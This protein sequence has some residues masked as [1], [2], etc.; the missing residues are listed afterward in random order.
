MIE[1]IDIYPRVSFLYRLWG[2]V[3]L[4]PLPCGAITKISVTAEELVAP[5]WQL[6]GMMIDLDHSGFTRLTMGADKLRVGTRHWAT[7]KITCE[8]FVAQNA[9]VHCAQ[10]FLQT[11]ALI[12]FV[13]S[14]RLPQKSLDITLVPNSQENWQAKINWGQP[15]Q[16]QA[17]IRNGDI[18]R[19]SPWLPK[20]IPE[21]SSGQL[22]GTLQAIASGKNVSQAEINLSLAQLK[23]SDAKGLH[24]GEK[25]SAA[26]SA[27]IQRRNA[28]WDW[29]SLAAWKAGE[30]FW[31]PWYAKAAHRVEARGS[32]DNSVIRVEQGNMSWT[33]IGKAEF[34]G[35]WQRPTAKWQ[36][37]SVAARDIDLGALQSNFLAPSLRQ[38][39][40]AKL[41]TRGRVDI[42][43]SYL[44]GQVES[45]ELT[46]RDAMLEDGERRFRLAGINLRLP[47]SKQTAKQGDL[48]IDNLN[49]AK[50]NMGPIV[51]QIQTRG[52][53]L[54][55][56]TLI[57]PLLD[58]KLKLSDLEVAKTE[59]GWQAAV[60]G[61]LTP[62]NMQELAPM[63][64]LPAMQGELSGKF[65]R[66]TFREDN[67]SAEGNLTARMFD[68]TVT[69]ENFSI[70]KLFSSA[71]I[72]NLDVAMRNLDLALLTRAFSFGTME[73][74]IDV[75]IQDLQTVNWQPLKFDA[76]LQSSPGRYPKK[77]SQRAVQ[78]ISSLGGAGPAAAL[79]RSFLSFF[80]QFGYNRLALSC[81]LKD[82]VCTMG[83]IEPKGSGFV[84]VEGGGIPAI[85]VLG[86]NR[87]VGWAELVARLGRITK[88]STA[89][90]K[91][92][93]KEQ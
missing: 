67:L 71:P 76:R 20:A 56:K 32:A 6:Q 10:G 30:I 22:N 66:L 69:V 35:V 49:V 38:P 36:T 1:E 18:K 51:T 13:F 91:P 78:N 11:D 73:G 80:E 65:P 62:V 24:A 59:K 39:I 85:T 9:V 70:A 12:P 81:Q 61:E 4:L 68:G 54:S 26:I 16:V 83:G 79:Q 3:L 47:W 77:I 19:L 87:E 86:Y 84:I 93:E 88:G 46:L 58:G 55:V 63:L 15:F 57:A 17:T 7:P 34:S 2:L 33:G 52:E 5:N 50:L 90:I 48:R 25:I 37:L 60:S 29:Q 31:Q 23:F 27:K 72:A 44:D 42:E 43:V 8:K 75:D 14:A 41:K 28:T 92:L 45:A 74:R 21:I 82:G 53:N 89:S 64:G 40:L